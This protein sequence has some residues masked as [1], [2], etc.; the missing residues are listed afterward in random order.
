MFPAP[1][2]VHNIGNM[3]LNV[4]LNDCIFMLAHIEMVTQEIFTIAA[5]NELFSA[6]V[7]PPAEV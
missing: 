5:I 1:Y 3:S 7:H 6:S 2:L 4:P